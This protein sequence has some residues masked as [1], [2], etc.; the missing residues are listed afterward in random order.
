MLTRQITYEDFNGNTRTDTFY[1]HLSK[2]ELL[3]LQFGENG[4]DFAAYIQQ[5]VETSDYHKLLKEFKSLILLAYGEKSDDGRRFVK[6]PEIRE[7]FSQTNAYSELFM[8]LASDDKS[9]ADFINGIVPK[10]MVPDFDPTAK[11][12]QAPALASP[13]P[14]PPS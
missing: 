1:F 9:A 14:P 8:E 13:P 11:T 7:E 4:L 5:I 12:I 6:S 10:D 3:E 2:P